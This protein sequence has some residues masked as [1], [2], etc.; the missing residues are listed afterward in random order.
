MNEST[1]GTVSNGM[2]AKEGLVSFGPRDFVL[3]YLKYLPW[4]VISVA[5]SLVGAYLRIRYTPPVYTMQSTFLI[6]SD[7]GG[8]GQG[9]ARFNEIFMSTGSVNMDDEIQILKSTPVM[10]RVARDLNLQ[11]QYYSMGSFRS[12]HLYP[13]TP[14]FLKIVELPDSTRGF[15]INLKI[16]NDD[17]FIVG[18]SKTPVQ[19]GQTFKVDA[20]LCIVFRDRTID[21]QNYPPDRRFMITWQPEW[22]VGGGLLDGLTIKQDNDQ[23]DVLFLAHSGE[24]RNL[25][26]DVLNMLMKVYDTMAVEEKNVTLNNTSDF[27]QHSL[28][29]IQTQLE[30]AENNLKGYMVKNNV[31]DVQAQSKNYFDLNSIANKDISTMGVQLELLKLLNDYISN[32]SNKY[33]VVPINLG[34]AEPVLS[35]LVSEYNTLQTLRESHLKTTT[36]LNPM[37]TASEVTL[38]K[39]RHDIL[40]VLQT[41][42]EAD[43]LTLNALIR[44]SQETEGQLRGMP[45]K[46]MGFVNIQR[47]QKILEDLYSFL[48]QKKFESRM[49]SAATVSNTK[50]VEPAAG[51]SNPVKPVKKSIY[52][53]HVLLG[54]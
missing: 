43:S 39:T 15:A 31:F 9:D 20:N 50:V 49:S 5:I 1:N 47:R 2:L 38:T 27:I 29:T 11:T 28:D 48:L 30:N 26:R 51:S 32:E 35:K 52:T 34:V 6:K 3:K 45:S 13:E 18:E 53:F 16:I 46:S 7:R 54:F 40:E 41:E 21:L 14:I 36:E 44:K 8:N 33:S 12:T 17:Q 24:N 19:F 22:S 25:S 37:I 4:V 23:S 42:K 10:A